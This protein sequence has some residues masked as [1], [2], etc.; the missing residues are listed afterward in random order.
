MKPDPSKRPR[1]VLLQTQ[2]ENAGAQEIARIL[3]HGLQARGFDV[4]FGFF[5]RRTAG[6]DNARRACS[7][8]PIIA[9]LARSALPAMAS[10]IRRRI[11]DLQP[12]A[13]LTFQHYGNI[14]GAPLARAAG[15]RTVLANLNSTLK[16]LPFWVGGRRL[17]AIGNRNLHVRDCQLGE[18]RKRSFAPCRRRSAAAGSHRSW[19]RAEAQRAIEISGARAALASARCNPARERRTPASAEEPA[20]ADRTAACQSRLACRARG[21]GQVAWK[22]CRRGRAS[23]DVW[24]GCTSSVSCRPIRSARFSRRSTFSCSPRCTKRSGSPR[25]R[26]PTT[27]SPW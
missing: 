11:R 15:A 10:R 6:Y 16:A 4:H 24:I 5:F 17:A 2:A 9:R 14:F 12:D 27:A 25:S 19:L 3:G 7:S 23:S 20:G 18:S 13:V 22:L 8:A 1:I 26:P 21:A